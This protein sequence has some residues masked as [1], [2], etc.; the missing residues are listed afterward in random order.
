MLFTV[1]ITKRQRTCSKQENT[2]IHTLVENLFH[3]QIYDH[4]T[5]K[6]Q[7]RT[8]KPKDK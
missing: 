5:M 8:Y 1:W 2:P 7:N 3:I 4:E 6:I